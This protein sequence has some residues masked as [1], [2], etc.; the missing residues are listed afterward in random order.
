VSTRALAS[1][2]NS[3]STELIASS[4]RA[5][6]RSVQLARDTYLRWT[7]RRRLT[8]I[9]DAINAAA[10]AMRRLCAAAKGI[11]GIAPARTQQRLLTA[12]DE[13]ESMAQRAEAAI[14]GRPRLL[15]RLVGSDDVEAVLTSLR[16]VST[17]GRT[18]AFECRRAAMRI[19]DPGAR[20]TMLVHELTAEE[21][22][23][24]DEE[25]EDGT[26]LVRQCL[27]T[28]TAGHP[29]GPTQ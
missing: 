3:A 7:V 5:F 26:A 21:A 24:I 12:A 1:A 6:D 10:D 13:A 4:I 19:V 17:E 8:E 27:K 9:A 29:V 15:D 11:Q 16:T 28:S 20:S 25:D 23:G 2:S 22:A 18:V 14:E